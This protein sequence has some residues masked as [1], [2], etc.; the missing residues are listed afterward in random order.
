[1]PM[2]ALFSIAVDVCSLI[3][4]FNNF[5]NEPFKNLFIQNQPIANK[6]TWIIISN[7]ILKLFL[8]FS[9]SSNVVNKWSIAGGKNNNTK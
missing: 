8:F 6:I 5:S 9:S 1:M 3:V 7:N 4:T 2:L